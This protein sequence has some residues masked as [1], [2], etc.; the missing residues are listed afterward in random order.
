MASLSLQ[1]ERVAL[2]RL[3]RGRTLPNW[4]HAHQAFA[5]GPMQDLS[6][7]L[8]SNGLCITVRDSNSGASGPRGRG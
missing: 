6:S 2:T 5:M 3:V 4:H 1:V 8:A 7:F